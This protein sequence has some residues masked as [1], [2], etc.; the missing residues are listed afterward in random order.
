M[1]FAHSNEPAVQARSLR[2]S[3]MRGGATRRSRLPSIRRAALCTAFAWASL[4]AG[5]AMAEA[6]PDAAPEAPEADLNIKA[7]QTNQWT[8]FWNRPTMLG[9]IGG[10]RPWLGK[11]G[12][13]FA[14]TETSEVLANV[15]GGLARGADYDGLTTATVADGYAKGVRFARRPVQRQRLADPRGQPQRQQ[16]RHAEYGERHRSR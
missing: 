9:D 11:Y 14:L 5:A 7:T 15:R 16:A 6:N 13:T 1:K 12:V 4:T 3:A 10:L 8:G 2:D